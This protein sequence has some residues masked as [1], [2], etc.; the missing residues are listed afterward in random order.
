MSTQSRREFLTSSALTAAAA[1][2]MPTFAWSRR[3]FANDSP[4]D[5]PRIGCIGMGGMGKGDA[6]AHN[7]F[8]DI[9][10]CCDVDGARAGE[11]IGMER[12]GNRKA[13]ACTDY[14]RVL[15]R[16]D[17]DVVSVVTTDHW[18]VKIAIEALQAGK[19]VFCQKPLTLTLEENQLIRNACQKYPDQVFFIGTQQRSDKNNFLR[20]INMVQ[21]GLLGDIKKVTVGINGGNVGGPFEK[22]K[23]PDPLN[24]DMWLGQAPKVDYIPQR[25]HYTFRWWYEYSGGKF[26]DWGAH[27]I[28]ITLWALER[29]GEGQGPVTFDGT[30]AK[31]PVPFENGY[32]TKDDSF[33]T[34]HDYAVKCTFDDGVEMIVDSRSDNG[35]LFEGNQRP[36]LRHAGQD[37]RPADRGKLGQRPVRR[38]RP[39][40]ALQGQAV[41]RPQ[42]QLLPLPGRRGPAG[43][44]R[45]QPPADHE[46]LPP[47]RHRRAVESGHQL[48]PG[49][50]ADRRRRRGGELLWAGAAER[51]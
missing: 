32:P 40:A 16:N 6:R 35:I 24:W 3:S 34:A 12:I 31:H 20:A 25:C 50:R 37:Q 1:G 41:R 29:N 28:D 11:A 22:A 30:D 27:H 51:V 46:Q 17:I 18:H 14:R 44:R 48:G 19:H 33:N 5:R 21:K 13:I 38:R 36:D 9:L 42:E 8:G 45:L 39:R 49:R 43:L 10:M 4:N 26:T 7:N 2:F 47:Q 15:D 23:V